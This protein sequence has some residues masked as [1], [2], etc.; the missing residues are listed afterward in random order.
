MTDVT[1]PFKD[2]QYAG[3]VLAGKLA[4]YRGRPNLLVLTLP[5]G[6]VAVAFEVARALQAPLDISVVRKLGAAATEMGDRGEWNVGQL[7]RDLY[8]DDA[9][10]VGFSKHYGWV[11]AASD[12]D[13]PPRRKRVRDGF[14]GSCEDL[15]HQTGHTRFWLALRDEVTLRLLVAAKRLQR[16]I[17]VIYRPDTERQSHYFFTHLAKQ[18]DALI[19]IDETNA[20]DPLNKGSV[21]STGK[22]PETFPTGM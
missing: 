1:L 18:F 2:R 6:G 10:R 3:R 22:A 19:H 4:N 20:V 21:W 14:P 8:A 12:W 17:G 13:Y 15:F 16:A 11:T 7:M 9:V 5:C